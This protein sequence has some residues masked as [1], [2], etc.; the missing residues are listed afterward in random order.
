MFIPVVLRDGHE[1]L[2]NKVE[3]QNLISKK[4][5]L[6]FRRSEGWVVVGRDRMRELRVPYDGVERRQHNTF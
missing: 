5:I 6:F 2:V 4:K 1:E 3:L